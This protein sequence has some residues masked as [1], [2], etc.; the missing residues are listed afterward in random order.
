MSIGS[1]RMALPRAAPCV[2]SVSA[3]LFPYDVPLTSTARE[4]PLSSMVTSWPLQTSVTNLSR[5]HGDGEQVCGLV[6][7]WLFTDE[8]DGQEQQRCLN[9]GPWTAVKQAKGQFPKMGLSWWAGPFQ[10][11]CGLVMRRLVRCA[12][13][14]YGVGSER[15]LPPMAWFSK[16]HP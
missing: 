7:S 15:R 1:R 10:W 9:D 8:T 13:P 2:T 5:T 4:S 11:L 16:T 12:R 14:K 6:L 3:R